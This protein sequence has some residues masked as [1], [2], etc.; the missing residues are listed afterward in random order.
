MAN[1]D[2]M[3]LAPKGPQ[4]LSRRRIL[5]VLSVLGLGT[6]LFGRAL[7]ALAGDAPAVTT[8][9]LQRAEWISG[10]SFSDEDRNLMLKGMNEMSADFAK[11]RHVNLDNSVAPALLFSPES[12][13]PS[14]GQASVPVAMGPVL[15]GRQ[16]ISSR[17]RRDED[18]AFLPVGNLAAL[19]RNGSVSAEEL[20]R[21]YLERLKKYDPVLHCV[22]T[23]TEDL[24]LRQARR[25]DQELRR[26]RDRGPLHGIPWGAKDLLALPGYPTTWGAAPYRHQRRPETATVIRR[27][28]EAGAVLLAKTSVGALAWGDVWFKAQTR[29]PWNTD[30]G[31]SGSSAGSASAAAGGLMPFALGTETLG[32]IVSPSTRC[33]ATSLRPTFGRVSRHGAMALAWSMDKIGPLSRCVED[34]AL[35][36][37]AIAGADGLDPTAVDRPFHWPLGRDI[38][39]VRVG[40]TPSLFKQDRTDGVKDAKVRADRAEWQQ[41][42]NETL[43]VL[44]ALG[45]DLKPIHLPSGYPLNALGVILSAEA[46]AAFDVLTRSGDDD[47]LVRQTADAW[48][49]VFRQ[50]QMIPAVEYIRANRVRSM[51][52]AEM[53]EMMQSVDLYVSPTFAGSNLLLT[54]LTGHPQVV[55][56]NGFRSSDGT[57]TSI[58]FTG[59]LYGESELLAVAHAYQQATP[60]HLRRPP[61]A[62]A[63]RS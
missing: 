5:R 3:A 22:I 9:M 62:P 61:L 12:S 50:G 6:P 54:N 15:P 34:C 13:G 47:K 7:V 30:Q 63:P 35:I 1:D 44:R 45:L 39:T 10:L 18:L 48:P 32:S 17:P 28:E 57:P 14:G 59:R 20:T 40:F 60:F 43:S 53:A 2:P 27:L 23:L 16:A 37:A 52:M 33:G 26:G 51:V 29:N 19:L 31:S 8:S 21:L 36:L 56:P 4:S 24:A 41:F 55:L 49:N 25:A 42:D 46:A 11:L 58:T 38:R